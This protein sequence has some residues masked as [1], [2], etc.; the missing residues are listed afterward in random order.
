MPEIHPRPDASKMSF[1]A[2]RSNLMASRKA[3]TPLLRCA[4]MRSTGKDGMT[5]PAPLWG[6]MSTLTACVVV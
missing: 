5:S 3:A 2:S 1:C 4:T 6:V